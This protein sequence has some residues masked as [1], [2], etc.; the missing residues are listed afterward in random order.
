MSLQRFQWET[1]SGR[2]INLKIAYQRGVIG[3]GDLGNLKTGDAYFRAVEDVIQLSAGGPA[4]VGG[5]SVCVGILE[6]RSGQKQFQL[7]GASQHIEI[8]GNNDGFLDLFQHLIEVLQLV[9]TVT[10]FD[11]QVDEEDGAV[12]QLQFND[13]AFDAVLEI[14]K[15]LGHNF[16]VRQDC[17]P[18]FAEQRHLPGHGRG[19]IFCLKHMLVLQSPG[20]GL[21]LIVFL[22]TKGPAIHFDQ[23]RNIRVHRLHE[24]HNLLQITICVLKIP[25]VRHRKVELPAYACRIADVIEKKSHNHFCFVLDYLPR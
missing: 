17:I 11:G 20:D 25:A 8:P 12:F 5:F 2:V 10:E 24:L 18:L 13:K 16:L 23:S 1:R 6:A 3:Q 4:G 14:V 21:C 9:L 15:P 19:G 7:P 22:G